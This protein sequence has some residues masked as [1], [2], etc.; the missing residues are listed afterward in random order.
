MII[1]WV[2]IKKA[3]ELSGYSTEALRSKIRR[4]QLIEEH[5]WRKAQDGSLLIHLVHFNEWLKQ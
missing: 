2:K 4:H 3:A 5:H 1:E